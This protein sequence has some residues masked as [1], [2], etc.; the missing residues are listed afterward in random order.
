MGIVYRARDVK[1][2]RAVAIKVLPPHVASIPALRDRFL[3]E[4][5]TAAKLSHPN[6][7]PVH[8]ADEID[9]IAFF[10]MGLVEGESLG[11]RI[12]VRAPIPADELVPVLRDVAR[13]LSYAHARGVVHRDVKPE[14][15]LLDGESGRAMVTDFGIARLADASP[16]TATGQVLGTVHFMSP[17]QVSG[18]AMDGRSDLY[19]L[20]VVGYHALSGRL[21]FDSE[22]ATAVLVAHVTRPAPPLASVAPW[23]SG[24]LASVIDACLAKEPSAR[25]ATGD[26]LAAALEEA[27]ATGGSAPPLVREEVARALWARAAELQAATGMMASPPPARVPQGGR[28][29]SPTS[30]YRYEDVR[31]A[32]LEAGIDQRHLDRAAGELGIVSE[33]KSAPLPAARE[34]VA[35]EELAISDRSP[36]P[37][38]LAGAPMDLQLE[39]RIAGEVPESEFEFLV[40]LI[41]QE[42][43][44]T[45]HVGTLG[46]TLTWSST[47][48]KRQVRI[49]IMPRGGETVVHVGERFSNIAGGI[50]GGIVGGGGGGMSGPVI[51]L[52]IE[53]FHS[54]PITL[55]CVGTLVATSYGIARAIFGRIVRGREKRHRLLLGRLAAEITRAI[56]ARLKVGRSTSHRPLPDD[57]RSVHLL[58]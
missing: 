40:E 28:A 43:N 44:D 3:R 49:T 9:D 52:T 8:R 55:A 19:S 56:A 45:G 58:P 13:A 23:V 30:A 1:L 17:E 22:N 26:A 16:L 35:G 24:A 32:A 54:A 7:V 50:F 18:E 14:N 39:L 15:I 34:E 27:L 33:G 48:T 20:G 53:N 10:V 38:P 37:N 12:R 4:A 29:S 25:Y 47:N 57:R 31:A 51:A 36:T 21:P 2:D 6:I 42:M 11:D 46:R 41:R 5:R